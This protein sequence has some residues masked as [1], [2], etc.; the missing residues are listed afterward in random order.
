MEQTLRVVFMGTPPLAA[1]VLEALAQ[2]FNVVA[3]Y[4][5]PDAVRGR[6]NKLVP[7]AVKETATRLGIPVL[8]P[9]TLRTQ[10]AVDQLRALEPDVVCVAAYGAILPKEILDIPEYGC[11]NV[12]A[13]LLPRWRG[14]A[15]IERAILAGDER[16][17]VCIMRME[18]GLDT[19]DF[20]AVRSCEIGD[21]NA[22][23][24]TARLAELGSEALVD[25]LEDIQAGRPLTWTA[26]GEGESYAKKIDKGELDL[27]LAEACVTLVRKVRASDEAHP[28]VGGQAGRGT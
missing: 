5:R 26:Q 24:L 18:E 9:K 8:T 13:S 21:M 10:E 11:L 20:C 15:P 2:H 28:G 1:T 25:V 14:A 22:D 27:S 16:A 6:G 4:T 12:H 3:A 17:G 7:S 23:Q 19:G